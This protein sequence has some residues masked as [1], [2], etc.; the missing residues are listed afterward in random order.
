MG[1]PVLSPLPS[2]CLRKVARQEDVTGQ[3]QVMSRSCPKRVPPIGSI[4]PS[5]WAETYVRGGGSTGDDLLN[6]M[7]RSQVWFVL[8]PCHRFAAGAV[9]VS[10][11]ESVLWF[12]CLCPQDVLVGLAVCLAL[13]PWVQKWCVG[14]V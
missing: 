3:I 14:V 13:R 10:C 12:F 4:E 6:V 11:H 5:A 8:Q 1:V 7:R 2:T 9:V